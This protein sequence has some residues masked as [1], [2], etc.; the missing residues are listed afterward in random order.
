MKRLECA[1][2]HYAWGKSG[3]D[4]FVAHLLPAER[5]DLD[6]RYAELWMGTHPNGPS[7][8]M[9]DGAEASTNLKDFLAQNPQLLGHHEKGELSFLFKILSVDKALSIQSHPTKEQAK[10]LHAKDPANYPDDNHK[11]EMAIALTDFELLCGFQTPHGIIS[12]VKA[13]R[14][15]LQLVGEPLLDEL[16]QAEHHEPDWGKRALRRMFCQVWTSPAEQIAH[17]VAQI[18]DRIGTKSDPAPV[19]SLVLRLNS[20]FPGG[21]IGVL[22]PFFLNFF[23]LRPG[24][25]TFLGPNEPHAY[26]SG[27]NTEDV[28]GISNS[29][30]DS[31]EQKAGT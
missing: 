16:A 22:A 7:R 11:P 19:D 21:D 30:R 13:H 6:M 12:N 23:T 17:V 2:Q 5:V 14:E 25:A 1:V 27:A 31:H 28:V 4:S 24:Q 3:K 26:L 8:V 10:V 15:L 18:V 20:Q 9:D 29:L